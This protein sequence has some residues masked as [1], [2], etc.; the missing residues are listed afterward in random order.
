ME[1]DEIFI[2]LSNDVQEKETAF[3][4]SKSRLERYKQFQEFEANGSVISKKEVAQAKSDTKGTTSVGTGSWGTVVKSVIVA[5]GSELYVDEIASILHPRYRDMDI[6]DLAT[7]VSKVLSEHGP[8]HGIYN[9]LD[10]NNVVHG[11]H[12]KAKRWGLLEFKDENGKVKSEHK[13]KSTQ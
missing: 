2:L 3:Q 9:V 8:K 11:K 13:Y 10:K 7:K 5:K 6:K 4:A 1:T 12:F